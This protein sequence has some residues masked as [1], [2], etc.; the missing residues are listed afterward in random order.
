[1]M[2]HSGHVEDSIKCKKREFVLLVSNDIMISRRNK[3]QVLVQS[4]KNTLEPII[5]CK[6]PIIVSR[7]TTIGSAGRAPDRKI[8]GAKIMK[9]LKENLSL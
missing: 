9:K 2:M 3:I 5:G 8:T 4:K 1:M 7:A 6:H